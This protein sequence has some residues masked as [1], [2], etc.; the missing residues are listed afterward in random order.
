MKNIAMEYQDLASANG[1]LKAGGGYND[2]FSFWKLPEHWRGALESSA[3]SSRTIA[4]WYLFEQYARS[5]SERARPL[6]R[7]YYSIKNFLPQEIRYHMRRLSLKLRPLQTFPNWPYEETLL[8]FWRDWLVRSLETVGAGDAWHIG[9]WPNDKECCVV[10]THDVESREGF[11]RIEEMAE[12]EDRFGFRSAWNLPLDQY[13][14]D[15]ARVERLRAHGFEF[16]AHGLR[17]DG[18]LFRSHR[19]FLELAPRLEKLAREHGLRGFRS[20]STF[21]RAEWLQTLDFDFDSSFADSD[22]WE[23]QPGGCCSIFPYF[24]GRLIELPYTLAQDHTLIN[25]L[26]RDPLQEWMAKVQWL[27]S[28]GGMILALVHPDYSGTGKPLRAY[29][30]L[31]RR[32]SELESSW[33]ALPADV[34]A[35][36]NRRAKLELHVS[37]DRTFIAGPDASDATVRR[38]SREP[39]LAGRST[40]REC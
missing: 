17:H 1:F 14:I 32:L 24:I 38:L 16:G 21:R 3:A 37:G 27:A 28:R 5:K 12:M 8:A 23:P 9:F 26:H 29:Q 31:L 15:W 22:P 19:H 18:K 36:W 34:A 4:E 20:P 30:E 10:I 11:E 40:W 25:L 33:R 35:W 2:A 39:M 13:P 7:C 6:L